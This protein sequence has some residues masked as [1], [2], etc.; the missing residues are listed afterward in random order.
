MEEKYIKMLIEAV[1]SCKSAHK[2]ID[3]IEQEMKELTI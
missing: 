2:R 3:K 1:Q